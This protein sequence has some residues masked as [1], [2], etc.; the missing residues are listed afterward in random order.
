M[1]RVDFIKI[2]VNADEKTAFEE[3]AKT[4]GISL[5]AWIRERLR[6]EARKDLE[7]SGQQVPFAKRKEQ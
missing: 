2:R 4:A 5:S 7:E 6:R 1:A 3:A